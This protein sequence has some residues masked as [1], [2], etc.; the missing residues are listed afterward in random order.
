V[1]ALRVFQVQPR[2]LV[3]LVDSFGLAVKD[4]LLQLCRIHLDGWPCRGSFVRQAVLQRALAPRD[5]A[6]LVPALL[7]LLQQPLNDFDQGLVVAARDLMREDRERT[8][9]FLERLNNFLCQLDF[10]TSCQVVL[11]LQVDVVG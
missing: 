10:L 8:L 4:D 11:E 2:I 6:S 1:H 9:H 3:G 7:Q 5:L